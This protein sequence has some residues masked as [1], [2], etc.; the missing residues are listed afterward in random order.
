MQMVTQNSLAG[1]VENRQGC[2][3]FRTKADPPPLPK[4]FLGEMEAEISAPRPF[5]KSLRQISLP[6]VFWLRV[7]PLSELW[8]FRRRSS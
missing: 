6:N 5:S 3:Q 1:D 8:S 2:V 7:D 4:K